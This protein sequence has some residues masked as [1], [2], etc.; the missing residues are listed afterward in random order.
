[1]TQMMIELVDKDIETDSLTVFHKFKKLEEILN[2]L[3]HG[4][5]LKQPH[6]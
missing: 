2:I 6:S 5:F 1:M 4:Q 3:R